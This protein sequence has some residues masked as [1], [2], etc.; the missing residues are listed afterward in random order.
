MDLGPLETFS[1]PILT[2]LLGFSAITAPEIVAEAYEVREGN[3][4]FTRKV[5]TRSTISNVVLQRGICWYDSDF[6]RWMVSA[7]TG[8]TGGFAINGFPLLTVGGP[9]YRRSL[10]LIQYF[11]KVT[12]GDGAQG[13]ALGSAA[14][15]TLAGVGVLTSG[16]GGG[17]AGGATDA[18]ISAGLNFATNAFGRL[19]GAPNTEAMARVPARAWVL[20]GAVPTRYKSGTDFDA[21]SN[22]VSIGEIELAVEGMDELSLAG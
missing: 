22:A 6:Y 8:N 14:N 5:I 11:S 9:T 2:P 17:F 4:F 15:A 10:L 16:V 21:A 19:I 3:S 1:L 13:F 7:V 20:Q 18:L 12:F